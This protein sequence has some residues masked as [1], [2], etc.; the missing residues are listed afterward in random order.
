MTDRQHDLV[1]FGATGYTGGLVAEYLAAAAPADLRIALA[2]R[3]VA[4]LSRLRAILPGQAQGW[5]VLQADSGDP[6]GLARLAESTRLVLTTVGPYA[7]LGMPIVTACVQAGTDYVDL[8]GEIP[9]LRD[10]IDRHQEQAEQNRVRLV[11]ACG[12]VA[13]V[14]DLAMWDLAQQAAA[15]GAELTEVQGLVRRFAGQRSSGTSASTV[16][17]LAAV[18]EDPSLRRLM[19]D[20]YALSPNRAGEPDLGPQ[21]IRTGFDYDA[22]LGTWL[23]PFVYE[24]LHSRVV[25]R[26]NALLGYPYGRQLR[27]REAVALGTGLAS[28]MAR[29]RTIAELGWVP[30]A[31][32]PRTG[33]LVEPLLRWRS[34]APRSGPQEGQGTALVGDLIGHTAAGATF[35]EHIEVP[36]GVYHATAVICGEMALALLLDPDRI[37]ARHGFLTPAAAGQGILLERLRGQGFQIHSEQAGSRFDVQP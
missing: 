37:P 16:E 35:R 23:G 18:R 22:E 33:R 9:F 24:G 31:L 30:L 28:V 29:A 14:A 32:H 15:A 1:L 4:A 27:Y 7:R 19:G 11:Q 8:S 13:A 2:G 26:T 36:M 17:G 12:V 3:D 6:G 10:C 25:R 20:P 5:A 34:P 21:P